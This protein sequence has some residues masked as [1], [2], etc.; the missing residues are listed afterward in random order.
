[1]WHPTSISSAKAPTSPRPAKL[2]L[3]HHHGRQQIVDIRALRSGKDAAHYVAKYVSKGTVDAVWS[4]PDAA[5]E[6]VLATKGLRSCATYGTWRGFKLLAR[7]PDT[8]VWTRV[9]LLTT[10]YHD[11]RQG[12][13][14]ARITLRALHDQ[15]QYNPHR[16]EATTK[17]PRPPTNPPATDARRETTKPHIRFIR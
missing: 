2:R 5:Q 8:H 11:A 9:C 15:C 14:Y 3:A 10:L 6:W 4:D 12:L 13:S 1:M 17:A 7:L 16:T